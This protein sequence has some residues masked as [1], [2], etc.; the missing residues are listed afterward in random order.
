MYIMMRMVIFLVQW[1][2]ATNLGYLVQARITNSRVFNASS[3]IIGTWN[4]GPDHKPLYCNSSSTAMDGPFPV[5]KF[6]FCFSSVIFLS[7]YY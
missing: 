3:T 1:N 6:S 4:T 5:S 2:D 7:L